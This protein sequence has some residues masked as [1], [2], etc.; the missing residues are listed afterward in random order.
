MRRAAW[1]LAAT[2]GVVAGA[3]ASQ[4]GPAHVM[5]PLLH[6]HPATLRVQAAPAPPAT[7]RVLW[8]FTTVAD[9]SDWTESSDG[10]ER[11]VGMS[12]GAFHL[13]KTARFQ[14]AVL[15]SLLN[16]QPNGAGFVGYYANG[17]WDL[18]QFKQIN[19]RARAQGQN[20][21]YKVYLK[22]HDQLDQGGS[23]ESFFEMPQDS[24]TTVSLPLDSFAF[25]YRGR[26][27]DDAPPLDTAAITRIGLQIYGGVYQPEKQSGVSSLEV[28]WITASQ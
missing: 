1:V 28:D 2:A 21:R 3:A 4:S 26:R 15:F 5:Y 8:N 9:L 18:S 13:Q 7:E 10:T 16:P 27:V 12:T 20:Y 14:R 19:V 24:L 6:V 11:E 23:Y 17:T 25:Y 22:H